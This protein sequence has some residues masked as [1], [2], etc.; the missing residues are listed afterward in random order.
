MPSHL[1]MEIPDTFKDKIISLFG[2]EGENE[3]S[4]L[5]VDI[6]CGCVGVDVWVW[7]GGGGGVAKFLKY[8]FVCVLC[9]C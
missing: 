2:E 7:V 6:M 8:I 1:P 5:Q 3:Q 9:I 4:V